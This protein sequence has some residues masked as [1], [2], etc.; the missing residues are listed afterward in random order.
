MQENLLHF[1][2]HQDENHQEWLLLVHG[3]GGSIRTWKRQ[4][5]QLSKQYNLLLVELPGHGENKGKDLD[6]GTY[7][8]ESIGA[9]VWEVVDHLEISKIHL[10]GISL[11]TIICLQ[12]R[13]SRP[14]R[15][16]S[17]ILPGAIVKLNS[18]LK[19]LANFS[20]YL[21]KI[22]GYR[23]FY[24]LS[25]FIMMPRGNHKQSRDIFVKESKALTIQEFKNWTNLYFHLNDTLNSFFQAESQIPH[26][27]IMGSQDHLFLPPA[28]D[29]SLHHQNAQI[30]IVNDCGHVV[31][32]EKSETFNNICLSFLKTI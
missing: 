4:I 21:A 1:E 29:Y 6:I 2:T 5:D 15:V 9:K 22:I 16:L 25:A 30:S 10:I 7:S 13:I 17:M 28:K 27:L 12:M 8:F 31:S 3:A 26:L 14:D 20:L 11:G 32:I 18:K 24:K 23:N 19:I